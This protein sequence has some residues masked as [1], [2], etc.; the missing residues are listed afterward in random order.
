MIRLDISHGSFCFCQKFYPIS[1]SEWEVERKNIT[2][3]CQD[4]KTFQCPKLKL[5][6]VIY[7]HDKNHQLIDFLWSLGRSAPDANIKLKKIEL[8]ITS[9]LNF[10]GASGGA[11][12]MPASNLKSSCFM[13]STFLCAIFCEAFVFAHFL[14]YR[15]DVHVRCVGMNWPLVFHYVL[16]LRDVGYVYSDMSTEF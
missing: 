3:R 8:L 1:D 16:N 10:C 15:A 13:P 7:N 9:Y 5:I 6:E 14:A 12:Q 4:G 2:L 11:Y